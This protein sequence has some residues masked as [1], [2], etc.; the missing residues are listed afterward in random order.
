M[1]N[2]AIDKAMID[3]DMTVYVL[4]LIEKEIKHI[5]FCQMYKH[6]TKDYEI[7]FNA[8]CEMRIAALKAIADKL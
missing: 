2:T 6:A 3:L 5:R 4:G 1:K 8:V 7:D